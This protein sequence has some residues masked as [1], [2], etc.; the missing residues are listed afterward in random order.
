MNLEFKIKHYMM[1]QNSIDKKYESYMHTYIIR[2]MLMHIY[3]HYL[4]NISDYF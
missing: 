4:F 2:Y 1:K 3:I